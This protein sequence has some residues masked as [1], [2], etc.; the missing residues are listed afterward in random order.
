MATL[1]LKNHQR[2]AAAPNDNL[3]PRNKP[4]SSSTDNEAKLKKIVLNS[5]YNPAMLSSAGVCS[6]TSSR[7]FLSKLFLPLINAKHFLVARVL[8]GVL[9]IIYP[10]ISCGD[11]H[12]PQEPNNKLP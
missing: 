11:V 3:R 9:L 8:L 4:A 2:S 10:S 7:R 6:K 12:P 1:N 5:N